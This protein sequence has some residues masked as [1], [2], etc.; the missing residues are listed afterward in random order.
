MGVGEFLFVE[1]ERLH[2][3]AAGLSAELDAA[4][5]ELLERDAALE[6][7]VEGLVVELAEVESLIGEFEGVLRLVDSGG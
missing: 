5:R 1:V 2:G 6:A 3:V 4:R 7:R